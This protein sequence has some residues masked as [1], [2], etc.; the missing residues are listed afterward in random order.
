MFCI[1]I[2]DLSVG[3]DNR[4]SFVRRLCRG[5]ETKDPPAF[6]VRVT[7]QE[8]TKEQNGEAR[9]SRGYCES[10][11]IYRKLCC[12][13]AGYDAFLMH[14]AVVAVDDAAYVFAAP[15]GTGKTTH[16]RLWMKTF[17]D[18][19]RVINGDK[20]VFRFMDGIL[21]ACGTP[22]QGKERMGHNEMCP[23]RAVC[24]LERGEENRIRRLDQAEVNGRIFHQLLIP[25]D[26]Q[27]FN[28]FWTL[29]ER[30]TAKTP[31]YL[32]QC[33]REPEAAR[34]AYETM[35]RKEYAED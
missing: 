24:F 25:K 4:Y 14:A 33:N 15:S 35:R 8:I 22:W 10:H 5:Y 16:I 23:V 21:Y 20:P 32:L 12:R 9:F 3:I 29:L 19:A 1:K 30:M 28:C 26:E 7:E 17:G 27:E 2:A 11:C 31:F 18:R 13:L 34:L 6:T